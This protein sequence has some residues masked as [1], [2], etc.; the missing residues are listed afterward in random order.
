M[1]N[2]RRGGFLFISPGCVKVCERGGIGK[3]K[4]KGCDHTI[5]S[6]IVT[7][8]ATPPPPLRPSLLELPEEDSIAVQTRQGIGQLGT[9]RLKESY[10]TRLVEQLV[11]AHRSTPGLPDTFVLFGIFGIYDEL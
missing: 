6:S 7:E 5:K 9:K 10:K 11:L 3:V 4:G 8:Q 1:L 2:Y